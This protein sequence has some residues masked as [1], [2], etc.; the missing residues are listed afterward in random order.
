ML[1]CEM[2]IFVSVVLL[3]VMAVPSWGASFKKFNDQQF[4]DMCEDGD[5]QGVIE[6]IKAGANVNAIYNGRT[7]LMHAAI[8]G[9]T[10]IVNAL[11][12]AGANVNAKNMLGYTALMEATRHGR[13]QIVNALIEAGAD[14][15][16]DKKGKTALI[17]AAENEYSNPEIV[18]ALIDAGSYVKQ[19]DYYGQN[20]LDYARNNHALKGTDALKRLEELSK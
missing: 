6:A 19:R 8:Y 9:H 11:I 20:A 4:V 5:T 12:K 18:N 10:K 15:L 1:I 17:H 7:A 16:T 14:D 2:L 3:A 13:T